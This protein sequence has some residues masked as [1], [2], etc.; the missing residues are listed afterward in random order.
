MNS[1]SSLIRIIAGTALLILTWVT[2]SKNKA[3]IAAGEPVQLFGKT[4]EASA[5]TLN[6][7]YGLFALVAIALLALGLRGLLGSS[8]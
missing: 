3:A 7:A 8:K 2:W 4:I 6:L 5:G 1:I